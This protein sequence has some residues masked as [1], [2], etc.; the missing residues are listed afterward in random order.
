MTGVALITG[1]QQGIGFGIARAL[2]DLGYRL[3]IASEQPEESPTVR[4]A[5]A[6]LGP[7]ARYFVHDMKDVGIV[8]RLVDDVEER[9]GS[10]TTLVSNAGVSSPVRGDMLDV[11]VEDFEHVMAVNLEGAFFLARDVARRMLRRRSEDYRSLVF[12]TSVS[13]RMA[14]I[15]RAEYCISKSAASMM[16]R[17]FSVRLAPDGIGVFELQPG[18]I[19]TPMTSGVHDTYSARIKNGLVPAARWGTANDIADVITP[20]V[21]GRMSFS[22]GAAIPIDG[23]LS[24]QRL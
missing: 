24:V 23:A 19:D 4:S 2:V 18:I 13:A 9:L 11:A 10:I 6:D 20:I 8:S 5:M 1:G 16:A 7:N 12:I 3:A 22:T 15:E 21:R 14:S 17:L